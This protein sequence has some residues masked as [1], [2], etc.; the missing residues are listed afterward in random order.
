LISSLN[1]GIM[2]GRLIDPP[3]GDNLDWFPFDNWEQE[4]SIAQSLSLNSIELVIDRKMSS[5]NPLWT[6]VGRDKINRLFKRYRFKPIACCV[7]FIIDNSICDEIVFN[8]VKEVIKYLSEL[9]FKFVVMPLFG[10]SEL[11]TH[12]NNNFKHNINYLADYAKINKIYFLIETNCSGQETLNFLLNLNNK[13]IGVVYDIGN[14]TLNGQNIE[15]DFKILSSLI[16]HIHIKDKNLAG[17]NVLLGDGIVDFSS[18]FKILKINKYVG[19]YTL[20]TS[21]GDNALAMATRNIN[22]LK[23]YFF[24]YD[25]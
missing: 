25:K 3:S 15:N 4:F 10:L 16:S 8:R 23:D 11:K 19:S 9:N 7:N 5:N 18:F 1:I 24:N 21:R 20:E 2:Q 17:D 14:A 22:F 6:Q 13:N 12:K